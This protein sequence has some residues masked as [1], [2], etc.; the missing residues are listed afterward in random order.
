MGKDSIVTGQ[1]LETKLPSS[2]AV[3]TLYGN[4]TNVVSPSQ[5]GGN[6]AFAIGELQNGV[7]DPILKGLRP[8]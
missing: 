1:S 7:D 6:K 8:G 4:S 5:M 2:M 3:A